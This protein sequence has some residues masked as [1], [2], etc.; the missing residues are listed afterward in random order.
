MPVPA[1]HRLRAEGKLAVHE[2]TQSMMHDMMLKMMDGFFSKMTAEQG[3]G[4]LRMCRGI[5][6]E[7]E[8]KYTSADRDS[9]IIAKRGFVW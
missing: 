8:E 9:R 2:R 1:A 5:L 6:A 4:M 3:R 7:M